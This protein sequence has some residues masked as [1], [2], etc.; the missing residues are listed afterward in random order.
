MA[1][2]KRRIPHKALKQTIEGIKE[3]KEG[4]GITLEEMEKRL[5]D[6]RK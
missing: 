5:K 2:K 1:K 4:K 3:I 6:G